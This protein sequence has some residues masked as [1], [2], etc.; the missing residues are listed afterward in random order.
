MNT[1]NRNIA[2]NNYTSNSYMS[3]INIDTLYKTCL[4]TDGWTD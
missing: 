2:T 1:T 3:F 4:Q